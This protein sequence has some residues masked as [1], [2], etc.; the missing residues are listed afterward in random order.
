MEAPPVQYLRTKDGYDIAYAVTGEGRPLMW[1][2]PPMGHI[3]LH[4]REQTVVRPWL[5]G[6][7]GRFRLVQYDTRGEGM[8][9]RGLPDTVSLADLERDL[10]TVASEL[11]L[12][13]FILVGIQARAHIAIRYAAAHPERVQALVLLSSIVTIDDWGLAGIQ[14]L[15]AKDWDAYLRAIVGLSTNRDIEGVVS[16][17]KQHV[18]Q[19]DHNT[20]AR[21]F[22][23]SSVQ[24]ILP[25]LQV[26]TLVLH[27][28]LSPMAPAEDA[29]KL[30]A[31]IPS[32]RLVLLD[33]TTQLGDAEQGIKAIEDLLADSVTD[34]E[35]DK[36]SVAAGLAA[37]E[38]E[39]LHRFASGNGNTGT[40][41]ELAMAL[42]STAPRVHPDGLTKREV[43][44]LRLVAAGRS[45]REISELLVLSVRTVERHIANI[46]LKT[47]THGRAQI[48]AY[49]MRHGLV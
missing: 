29:I 36:A 42:R 19:A 25:R 39:V 33:G 20:L 32:A 49:A 47:E 35:P 23:G 38:G 8:S 9:T 21:L 45:S 44:V 13:R 24:D 11:G 41:H 10:E 4:W 28:R 48:T 27:P 5:V 6:L 34:A 30:A 1:G 46:Y 7:S 12:T 15:A 14:S 2:P 26:P 22:S 3:Q 40:M 16:Q 43:E 17:L 37:R 18:T 31:A